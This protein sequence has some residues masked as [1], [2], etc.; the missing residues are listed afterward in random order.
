MPTIQHKIAQQ[1]LAKLASCKEIDADK[2]EQIR[3]L[4]AAD[5]RPNGEDFAKVF[6]R[7]AG[8]DVK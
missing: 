8:G 6:S 5:K 3:A 2:L 4:L 1:F 7:P